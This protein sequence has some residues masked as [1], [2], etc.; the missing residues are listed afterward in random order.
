[1][2][3]QAIDTVSHPRDYRPVIIIAFLVA[4]AVNGAVIGWAFW[5]ASQRPM[6]VLTDLRID[7][8]T[9]IC[10]GEGLDYRFR[11]LASK[12]TPVDLATSV[13]SKV[14]HHEVAY[15]FLQQYNFTERTNL[16]IVRHWIL[17]VVHIDPQTGVEVPWFPGEYTQRILAIIPGRANPSRLEIPFKIRFDCTRKGN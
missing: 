10:P 1:M 6:V 9:S 7:N 17:P 13:E 8:S 16:D 5:A 2:E 12:A 3:L 11:L 15:S 4:I 14:A